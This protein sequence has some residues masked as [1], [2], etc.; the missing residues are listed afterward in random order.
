M[1]QAD[2]TNCDREP[3]HIP[4]KIQPHG[5]L[6]AVNHDCKIL[7]CSEN[8]TSFLNT[9]AA[10][11]LGK[12]IEAMEHLLDGTPSGFIR[13]A[14]GFARR[15]KDF[16]PTNPYPIEIADS[17]FNMIMSAMDD[18]FLLEFEPEASDLQSNIQ[19]AVG[20]SLSEIL[21]DKSLSLLLTNA[22]KQIRDIIHYD[23]VMVY[24]FHQDGHGEVVAEA[25]DEKLESWLG[26]H[27]PASDIPKQARELYKLNLIRLIADVNQEPSSILTLPEQANE[28]LDMTCSALRA[29]SPLHIQYLKNMGVASSFS[30][31]ILHQGELWGLVA[32]H[33][34][35]P[36]F[37]NYQQRESARLVGQVLSSAL[38]FRQ[39]EVDQQ[40]SFELR[41]AIERITRLL[42]RNIPVEEALFNHDTT[43]QDAVPSAGAALLYENRISTVGQ[44]P[45]KKCLEQL[46]AWI[47]EQTYDDIFETDR[48]PELFPPAE[49]YRDVAS[50][51][52]VCRLS[53]ELKEYLIWFR[54]EVLA[55]VNWAGN[56]NKPVQYDANNVMHISPRTSFEVWKEQV[57]GTA[58]VWSMEDIKAAMQL[59][60]E[61]NYAISRKA[62]E[63]RVLNEKLREAYAELD[64][65]SYTISH[66]LKNPLTTIKSYS[67]LIARQ[68]DLEPKVR[69]MA[70]RIQQGASKMQAMIEEVL[71]Y[72][73]V[74]Q[75]KLQIKNI[76]MHKMLDD[77]RDGLMVSAQN[78]NLVFNIESA[79]DIQGE[80]TMVFQVF[81][82]L[83]SNAVKYSQKSELPVVNVKGYQTDTDVVYEINDNGIGIPE[84]EHERIFELF[85]RANDVEGFEGTG[86]GLSIVRRIME[87]HHGR[88]WLESAPGSGST[89][90]VSFRHEVPAQLV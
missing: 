22:A 53:K 5:F 57:N 90:F 89:F 65:F 34:Y 13:Q 17:E 86:V 59:R 35:T 79:P 43:L 63:L 60:D 55:T 21:V 71:Q 62:T 50:G 42:L 85:S 80:E 56:P 30:V 28:P 31:S 40:R 33:N 10:Y 36:R 68:A 37:I 46:I 66:D 82:N 25:R 18:Y 1:F 87:K 14:I 19:Q 83:L 75:A 8:V 64:S 54:P 78:P 9:S 27:Y 2:L 41:Q 32:C 81:S 4:G 20:R 88:I 49:K 29:V 77:L 23:R 67:Q 84:Q 45:D 47:G 73:K 61:V 74:G 11:L 51:L 38:S 7:Y 6:V 12:E 58:P 16:R 44:V 39:Q 15:R 48:L 76:D 26:L 70:D 52:L 72:S 69:N 24:Q 3:I